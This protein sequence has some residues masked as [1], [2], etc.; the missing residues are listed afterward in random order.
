[1]LGRSCKVFGQACQSVLHALFGPNTR[2]PEQ[3]AYRVA[4]TGPVGGTHSGFQG[5][6]CRHT[7][8]HVQQRSQV[9][10]RSLRPAQQAHI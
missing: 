7:H 6:P 4:C 8:A 2:M 9:P 5:L 3:Q 1:M 10:K